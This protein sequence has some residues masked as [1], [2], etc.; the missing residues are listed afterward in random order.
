MIPNDIWVG[1]TF[2]GPRLKILCLSDWSLMLQWYGQA[3]ALWPIY[4]SEETER[5]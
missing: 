2:N 3:R 1:L 5:S 4:G